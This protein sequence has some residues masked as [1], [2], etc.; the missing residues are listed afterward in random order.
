M[1]ELIHDPDRVRLGKHLGVVKDPRT[2]R[3]R[4]YLPTTLP[5]APASFAVTNRVPEYPMFANDVYGDCTCASTAHGVLA[6]STRMQHIAKLTDADVLELYNRVNGGEDNGAYL[7]DVLKAVR[8]YGI[9]G[10]KSL[11]YMEV[12]VQQWEMMKVAAW[13]FG[14]LY[15]GLSLPITAQYQE[16]WDV[17]YTSPRGDYK[18]GSWGGHAVE[19]LWFDPSGIETITWSERKRMTKEFVQTYCDE[20][21]VVL[22]PEWLSKKMISPQ[23]FDSETLLA[24]LSKLNS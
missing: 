23:H 10:H 20:A 19:G 18:P 22:S 9:G 7:F 16:V 24:D 4:R 21:Y 11:A 5:K 1:T 12:S 6:R 8:K 15:M 17:D 2:Y 3:A 13:L 14:G